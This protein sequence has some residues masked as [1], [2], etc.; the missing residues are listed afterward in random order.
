MDKQ[1]NKKQSG[2]MLGAWIFVVFVAFF[3]IIGRETVQANGYTDYTDTMK[4]IGGAVLSGAPGGVGAVADTA[5]HGTPFL[6][7]FKWILYSIFQFCGF[8]VSAAVTI[9][10]WVVNPEYISGPTGFFNRQSVYDM[11]KFVRDFF[12]LFFILVLLYTAFSIIFQVAKD[13][14]KTLLNLVIMA[15]LVNFSFPISRFII[16]VANVPMY[17][18]TNQMLT[19]PTKP[20]E[21]FNTV[22]RA[23]KLKDILI[24]PERGADSEVVNL[25]VGIVFMFLFAVTLLV[26][27]VMFVIRLIA[28]LILVIFSSVGF[29]ATII[30]GMSKYG[31]QWWD[32]LLRYA[33]FGPAAMLLLLIATRFLADIGDENNVVFANM[34]VV[35]AGATATPALAKFISSMAFFSI[36]IILIWFTIGLG[37][38]MS[39]A[40]ASAV[41]GWGKGLAKGVGKWAT[42]DNALVRG[43]ATGLQQNKYT[44]RFTPKYWKDASKRTEER[45][46]AALTGGRAGENLHNKRVGEAEKKM[47]EERK[48]ESEL[49]N[50]VNDPSKHSAADV[51]AAVRLLSKKD[52]IRNGDDMDDAIDAIQGANGGASTAASKEKVNELVKK[53]GGEIYKTGDELAKAIGHLGND[54]KAIAALID[55]ASGDALNINGAQYQTIVAANPSV[56]GKLDGKLKKEGR[57]SVLIDGRPSGQSQRDAIDELFNNMTAEEVAKQRLFTDPQYQADAVAHMADLQ[58]GTMEDVQRAAEIRKRMT[59]AASNAIP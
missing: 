5:L 7:V 42:Y 3:L 23:S 16:D 45:I 22:L 27:A 2:L 38:K 40:G 14:K 29:A 41:T 37:Q 34:Q 31:S 28:L 44:K 59:R 35:G 51:E 47:E 1:K 53:A 18:F 33:F 21:S 4:T 10:G 56:R 25:I 52:L 26:L 24:P 50:I 46:A 39:L 13:Y 17:F 9:F 43:A 20:G 15:L 57:T 32:A 58:S 55:K 49:R 6:V 54:T 48:S 12:N 19:D 30:P 8:L 36:P 11:W